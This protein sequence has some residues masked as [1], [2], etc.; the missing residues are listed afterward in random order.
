MHY[1]SMET[2][3]RGLM[4]SIVGGD[5]FRIFVGRS[6]RRH[7]FSRID[8]DLDA[9]DL[10]GA[11]VLIAGRDRTGEPAIVRVGEAAGPLWAPRL[12]EAEVFAHWLAPTA[13]A[14]RA[15]IAD[16][17]GTVASD[18]APPARVLPRAA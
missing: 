12:A 15:L 5:R 10:D 17:G 7:V 8:P 3:D 14:R 4:A 6:G 16:L 13:A 11:V 2:A 1:E 18:V 9:A